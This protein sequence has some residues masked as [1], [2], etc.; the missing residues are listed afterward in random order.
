M[1]WN[2]KTGQPN[3]QMWNGQ[4]NAMKIDRIR[5]ESGSGIIVWSVQENATTAATT[6]YSRN[7]IAFAKANGSA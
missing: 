4:K 5:V 2:R 3:E 6:V 1:Q 7:S